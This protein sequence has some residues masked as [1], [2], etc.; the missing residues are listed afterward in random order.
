M[1]A[2][3][4]GMASQRKLEPATQADAFHRSH[5]RFARSRH[6]VKDSVSGHD[7]LLDLVESTSLL[8]LVKFLQI[9]ARTEISLFQADEDHAMNNSSLYREAND[10]LPLR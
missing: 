10:F 6:G 3:D 7:Q 1:T 2:S 9:S 8:C 5:K 4:P